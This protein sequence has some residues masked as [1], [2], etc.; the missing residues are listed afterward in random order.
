M[1][2]ET[3][4]CGLCQ[5]PFLERELTRHHCKPRS[6]GGSHHHIALLCRQCHGMVHA[7]YTNQTLA[8]MYPTIRKLREAPELES[9]LKWVRKQPSSRRKANKVRKR[10]L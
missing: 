8:A 4:E 9:Y 10:K 7:T 1:E 6:H 2:R 3:M 5:R